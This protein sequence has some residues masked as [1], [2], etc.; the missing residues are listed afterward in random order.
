MAAKE[1]DFDVDARARLKGQ[2]GDDERNAALIRQ[3]GAEGVDGLEAPVT[4]V[5][6]TA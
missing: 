2:T 5:A 3:I 1:L 6:E 4:D